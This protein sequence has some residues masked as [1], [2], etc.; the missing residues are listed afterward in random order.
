MMNKNQ[1]KDQSSSS[2]LLSKQEITGPI[3][4]SGEMQGYQH[5]HA[6]LP[7][8]IMAMAENEANHRQ[9]REN[10]AIDATIKLEEQGFSERKL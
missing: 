6:D 9:Q 10:K 7:L 2:Q 1:S 8:R 4:S 5:I 3:P